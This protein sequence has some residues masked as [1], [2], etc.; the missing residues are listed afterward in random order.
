MCA[1]S[2]SAQLSAMLSDHY[3]AQL[4]FLLLLT[5][6]YYFLLCLNYFALHVYYFPTTVILLFLLFSICCLCV[7]TTTSLLH[8]YYLLLCSYYLFTTCLLLGT[9]CL[10]LLYYMLATFLKPHSNICWYFVTTSYYFWIF[11]TTFYYFCIFVYGQT[12]PLVLVPSSH[13]YL[14]SL[15]WT[16]RTFYFPGSRYLLEVLRDFL[17]RETGGVTTLR[18]QKLTWQKLGVTLIFHFFCWNT[19]AIRTAPALTNKRILIQKCKYGI[20]TLYV[21]AASRQWYPNQT[22]VW[23]GYPP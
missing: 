4:P 15:S 12:P 19:S 11:C 2:I 21:R 8:A 22:Q 23:N 9:T 10:L 18:I 20:R 1:L 16:S 3:C 17:G 14:G 6:L 13:Y 7:F 5:A